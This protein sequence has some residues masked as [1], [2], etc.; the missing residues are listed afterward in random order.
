MI[1]T[2][3]DGMEFG[4]HPIIACMLKGIFGKHPA[5]PRCMLTYDSDLVLNFL[6]SLSWEDITLKW[7][8]LKTVTI[9]D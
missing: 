6:K 2:T 7:S 9:L 5:L 3:C 8:N 4:K 1:L